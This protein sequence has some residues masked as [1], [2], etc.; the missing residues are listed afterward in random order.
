MSQNKMSGKA[1]WCCYYHSHSSFAGNR[2]LRSDYYN[3]MPLTWR[4]QE[5]MQYLRIIYNFIVLFILA[6]L[7]MGKNRDI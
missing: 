3:I 6:P 2:N 7:F 5:S 4:D 1:K